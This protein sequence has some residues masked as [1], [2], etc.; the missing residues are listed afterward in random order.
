MAE[1]PVSVFS[2]N[3]PFK[4]IEFSPEEVQF[5]YDRHGGDAEE[6]L[7]KTAATLLNNMPEYQG[8]ADYTDLMLGTAPILDMVPLPPEERGKAV[9]DDQILRLFTSMKGLGDPGAPTETDA[10]LSGLT[11]GTTSTA[12]GILGAKTAV[13]AA[14][15]Y[16][17]LPGPLAP[18]GVFSKPVAGVTG[19]LGGAILGDLFIGSPLSRQMFTGLEDVQLTP[20][21]EATYRG[22]ESAGNIAPM[23]LSL[24][25]L[26]PKAALST[27]SHVKNLPLANQVTV[28]SADDMANPMVTKYLAGKVSGAPTT[29]QFL[30]LRDK[31]FREAKEA[32]QEITLKEAAKQAAQE[33]NRSGALVRGTSGFISFAEK[34]LVSGGQSFRA[35]SPGRKA[36]FLGMEATAIPITGALVNLQETE[37]PRSPGYRVAA[38]TVGG[39]APNLFLLKNFF[40]V[41]DAMGGYITRVRENRAMGQPLDIFGTKERAKGRAIADIYDIFNDHKRGPRRFSGRYGRAHGGSCS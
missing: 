25:F 19:F 7:A 6:T 23:L 38:E 28:L 9:T 13:A 36:G 5:V 14:P 40:R 18:L 24:P 39:L 10:F 1:N 31:I 8:M 32:G 35:L 15:P 30:T 37:A 27:A 33:L 11:R 3:S 34:A 2:E 17:P 41:K 26:A 21:A 22:Y 29:R 4:A 16:V 20:S 12:T